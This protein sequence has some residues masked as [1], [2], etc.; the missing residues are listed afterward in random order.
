MPGRGPAVPRAWRCEGRSNANG[1]AAPPVKS[2]ANRT[3]VGDKIH[4]NSEP[5]ESNS[6]RHRGAQPRDLCARLEMDDL[7]VASGTRQGTDDRTE[8]PERRN[9]HPPA[10]LG[11]RTRSGRQPNDR[12]QAGRSEWGP[13]ASG[14]RRR[15]GPRS[16]QAASG[17]ADPIIVTL[18]AGLAAE[19]AVPWAA[20][21]ISDSMVFDIPV[22]SLWLVFGVPAALTFLA[23]LIQWG[24]RASTWS[25]QA[26]RAVFP[27]QRG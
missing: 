4:I 20:I 24:V 17:K 18:L 7:Q 1:V 26:A 23:V 19:V 25:R 6:P 5:C 15:H 3:G 16:Y 14:R 8:G 2:C 12:A 27:A 22:W 13:A 21:W 10:A 11:D 9:R